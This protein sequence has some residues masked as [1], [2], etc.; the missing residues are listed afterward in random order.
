MRM[1]PHPPLGEREVHLWWAAPTEEAAARW[2]PLL[3]ENEVAAAN[4]F[5]FERHRV[6]YAFAHGMLR[7]TL[8]G[9]T[10]RDP[11]ALQFETI[12]N[13]R[14]EL[15]DRAVRFNLSHTKGLVL[16]GVTASLDLGVDVEEVEPRRGE[17]EKLAMRVFAP[18]ELA[19]WREERDR[20]TTFY[21]RW[22]L[23]ESYIKA[24]GDG[25]SLELR[26]FGFPALG[27]NPRIESD[28]GDAAEWQFYS[29]VPCEGYR[30]AA[31]IRT[32]GETV[33]WSAAQAMR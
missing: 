12:G 4:R 21:D 28:F 16:I 14:P 1:P 33:V 22:T 5:R 6:L 24:R 15:I 30:A 3:S 11:R 26:R 27:R 32:T 29:F 9:Y 10:G 18:R 25:L 19:A 7:L 23:K 31:A 13:G 17:D 20:L 2:M 8:A